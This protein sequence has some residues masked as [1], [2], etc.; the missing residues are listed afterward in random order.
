MHMNGV[1]E[2]PTMTDLAKKGKLGFEWGAI[3]DPDPVRPAGDLG[4]FPFLRDPEQ[5]KG[6]EISPEKR[7]GGLEVIAWMNKHSICWATAGHIPAYK[8]VTET[9][10]TRRCSR[11]RPIRRSPR[12]PSTIRTRRSPASPRRSTRRPR[13]YIMPAINGHIEP[14]DAV[15]QIADEL[16]A[17]GIGADLTDGR[18]RAQAPSAASS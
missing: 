13:N 4:G 10:S 6:K 9:P 17:S 15:E 5:R 7:Q 1:W 14:E 8:P 18:R 2:V 12:P 16:Q 11:T 3:A